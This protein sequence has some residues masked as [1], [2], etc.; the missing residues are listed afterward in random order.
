V[1]PNAPP[2]AV[3]DTNVIV[4]FLSCHDYLTKLQP[5]LETKGDDAWLDPQVAYRLVRARDALLLAIHFADTGAT[6]FGSHG[7]LSRTLEARVPPAPGEDGGKDW[8]LD[9]LTQSIHLVMAIVLQ[10]WTHAGPEIPETESSH[11][12][13]QWHVDQAARRKIPLIT[14]EGLKVDGTVDHKKPIWKKAAAATVDVFTPRG[15]LTGKLANEDASFEAFL[16]RFERV[17]HD[18]V[19]GRPDELHRVLKM[20]GRSYQMVFTMGD[21]RGHEPM[22]RLA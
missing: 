13:D 16:T 20:M 21:T 15:Y 8:L 9:Y 6:T 12:A 19:K 5:A 2:V 3:L 14:N 1:D 7:E 11:D 22:V 4:D 17:A 18:Y 10:G